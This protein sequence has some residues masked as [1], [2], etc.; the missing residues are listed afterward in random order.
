MTN[1][2]L[3]SCACWGDYHA[4]VP[5]GHVVVEATPGGSRRNPGKYFVVPSAEYVPSMLIDPQRYAESKDFAP[6][7]KLARQ[8]SAGGGVQEVRETADSVGTA[9][10]WSAVMRSLGGAEVE[11]KPAGNQGGALPWSEV[12]RRVETGGR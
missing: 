11:S 6:M 2:R 3:R 12:M 10:P 5:E 9:L 7:K 1:E 4:D 8:N